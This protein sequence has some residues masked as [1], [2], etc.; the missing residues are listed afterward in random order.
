[1]NAFRPRAGVCTYGL[2][3]APTVS[4]KP[5]SPAMSHPQAAP[6]RVLHFAEATDTSGLFPQLARWHRADHYLMHFGTLYPTM[7]ALKKAMQSHAVPTFSLHCRSRL[8]FPLAVLHLSRF[9][10]R[11]RIDILHGHL[12]ESGLVGLVAAAL[13]RSPIRV[14]TRHHSNYHARVDKRWHVRA[15]RLSTAL[16]HRVIAVSRH[17]AQHLLEVE[18]APVAK[19]RVIYNGVDFER[20]RPS[21]PDARIRVRAAE[22]IAD[23]RVILVAGRLHPEKGYEHFLDAVGILKQRLKHP[24]VVLI[25][26]EGPH[27]TS[28]RER[29]RRLGCQRVVRFLGFR[30][31]LSD[32]MLASDV[33]VLPS[34]AEAFGLVL[35]E[36]LYLG[37]PVVATR[38]G[39]IPEIV[40]DGVD[41]VLVPPA[42]GEALA[43][44]IRRLLLEQEPPSPVETV[45]RRTKMMARFGFERMVREYEAVYDEL[46]A[47]RFHM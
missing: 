28:Y 32:L 6:R 5:R 1:V 12:F 9:L 39:G 36:A 4:M 2:E 43:N 25:A 14:L 34:V 47:R 31:D 11:E 40:E 41:G 8:G 42:D 30:N 18:K 19:V 26:G 24:F 35:V 45:R 21:G 27:E 23:E 17:T 3:F 15:D 13:A 38:V 16:S 29:A 10:R 44:A 7:P 33:F 46:A 20:L 37:L 22:S